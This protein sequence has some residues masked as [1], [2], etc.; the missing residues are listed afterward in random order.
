VPWY[1]AQYSVATA[2]GPAL[3]NVI[4][5]AASDQFDNLSF[6]S[7]FGA[8]SVQI[9][10]PGTN[11]TYTTYPTPNVTNILLHNFDSNPAGLGYTFSGANNS[12]GST[13]AV[14]VSSPN[15][16]TDSPTGN[17]MNNTNSFATGPVFSTVGQHGCVLTGAL[18]LAFASNSDGI[19]IQASGDGGSVP[20]Q[21]VLRRIR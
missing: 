13:N 17:Y 10:A 9:A 12:W 19:L 2:C 3:P 1:P 15:S 6:F 18:R 8:T 16:L 7:S 20:Y 5:V 21:L 11:E 14:S 4:A